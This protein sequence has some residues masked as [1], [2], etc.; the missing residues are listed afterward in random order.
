MQAVKTF[1]KAANGSVELYYDDSKKFETNGVGVTVY[2]QL[3]ATDLNISGVSTFTGNVVF[4]EVQQLNV[5]G[6]LVPLN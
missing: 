4:V 6:T 5:T 3:D 2:N 1:S